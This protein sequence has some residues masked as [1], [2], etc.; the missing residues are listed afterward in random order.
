MHRTR[1]CGRVG[2]FERGEAAEFGGAM[3]QPVEAAEFGF[4]A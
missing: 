4:D 1:E 3:Q 2:M